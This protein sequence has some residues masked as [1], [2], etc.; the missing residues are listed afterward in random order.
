[1]MTWKQKR[2]GRKSRI[3]TCPE[4]ESKRIKWAG[5]GKSVRNFYCADCEKYL[6]RDVLLKRMESVE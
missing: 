1:M 4:C 5:N 3:L 6:S 2:F